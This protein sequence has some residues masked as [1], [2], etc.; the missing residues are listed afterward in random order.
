MEEHCA[1][2]KMWLRE[3]F[4]H[5]KIECLKCSHYQPISIIQLPKTCID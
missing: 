5:N 3:S 2:S 1:L 4:F